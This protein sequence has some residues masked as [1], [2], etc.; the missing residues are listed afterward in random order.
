MNELFK[1]MER[2]TNKDYVKT[3]FTCAEMRPE[4][5]RSDQC[6]RV[7]LPVDVYERESMGFEIMPVRV[8]A[9]HCP[10]DMAKTIVRVKTENT[11]IMENLHDIVLEDVELHQH[12]TALDEGRV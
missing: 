4:D 6:V 11:Y 3:F 5:P 2:L 1:I 12:L 10:W 9:A 7:I 8:F